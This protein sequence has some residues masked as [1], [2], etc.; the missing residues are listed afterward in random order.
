MTAFLIGLVLLGLTGSVGTPV[1]SGP[2]DPLP[3]DTL[4]SHAELPE[5][6]VVATRRA[7]D[8]ATVPARVSV[9]DRESMAQ[10][11]ATSVADLLGARSGA[12]L[13][14][15]GPTGLASMSLR[16]MGASQTTVLLDGTRITDPQLGQLDLSLLP[17]AVLESVEVM[18]GATSPL[19]GSDGMGGAVNLRTRTPGEALD[20]QATAEGGAF[21]MRSGS[22]MVSGQQGPLRLLG[23]V[24][25]RLTDGDF[26]FVDETRFDETIT[27]RRNADREQV[28]LFGSA[29]L[30]GEGRQVRLSGWYTAA[31]RGLPGV[32]GT[33][34]TGERQ[35]DE[36]LRLWADGHQQLSWGRVR[37]GGL[38]Q[39][40]T[41]RYQN[42]ALT[43]D[44]TGQTLLS[45]VEVEAT[46]PLSARWLV[47]GGLTA[48]YSQA[49][50]PN[51]TGNAREGHGGAFMQATGQWGRLLLYPALR[52]D[53]YRLTDGTQRTAL[54]PRLG[55]NVA[56]PG[57]DGLRAKA[58]VGRAFRV[59]TFNDRFWQPGGNPDLKVERGLMADAG[60]LLH[61]GSHRAEVTVFQHQVRDQIVWQPD[62]TGTWTPRNL[63]RVRSRGV[64]ASYAIRTALTAR[65]QL[66]AGLHLTRTQAL[67]RSDPNS[68]SFNKQ[69]RYVPQEE[70]KAHAALS[71][72]IVSLGA[73]VHYTGRRFITADESRAME[74]H[75]VVDGHLRVTPVLAGLAVGFGLHLNNLFDTDYA[76]IRG[77]PMPPRH[78]H[79]R[80]TVQPSR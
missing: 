35:T 40:K 67:N 12:F 54:S 66:D 47:S 43:I 48:A 26:P 33:G 6:T 59:P 76:I 9:L 11:G 32:A 56:L 25:Y 74:P 29:A 70:W 68:R 27:R 20:W 46:A 24:D 37:V 71:T 63:Q 49:A 57:I 31:E 5:V 19:Y 73:N 50:H 17:T 61:R 10:T 4:V 1:D 16:G 62:A 42:P 60:L 38:L 39:H 22:A 18:H 77:Y 13:R 7:V 78:L 34:A 53:T 72:G 79:L 80:L 51:L 23:A 52:A 44:D 45:S 28:S 2:P 65:T 8:L 55:L 41:L 14:R 58:S 36:A 69:L 30:V 3:P 21:G 64:E 15:L 75:A